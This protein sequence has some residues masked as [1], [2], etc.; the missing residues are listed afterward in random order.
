MRTSFERRGAE[1]TCY[2]VVRGNRREILDEHI[3]ETLFATGSQCLTRLSKTSIKGGCTTMRFDITGLVRLEDFVRKRTITSQMLLGFMRGL[4]EVLE[5]CTREHVSSLH[6]LLDPRHVYVRGDGSVRFVCVPLQRFST[7]YRGTPLGLTTFL[8]QGSPLRFADAEAAFLAARLR[9]SVIRAN[10]VFSAMGLRS[11][12]R[13]EL[14]EEASLS[15]ELEAKNEGITATL[16]SGREYLL[17][18]A[19]E[20]DLALSANKLVSREH[21]RV[22]VVAGGVMIRDLE[23]TNGTVVD[24]VELEPQKEVFVPVGGSFLLAG[25]EICVK[26]GGFDAAGNSNLSA[27]TWWY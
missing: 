3:A 14:G 23:S 20:C 8:S 13:E 11:L 27:G 16:A 22:R 19:S 10:G 7:R 2:L 17:G 15:I 25:E 26:E 9:V 18:R 24:G 1:G 6:L 12:L 5:W 4:L 21:A